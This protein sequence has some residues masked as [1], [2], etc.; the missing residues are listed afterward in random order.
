VTSWRVIE[1][2]CREVLAALPDESVQCC[3]TSPPYFGLRDYGVDGQLGLEP[4]P[5]E[6]VDALAA[7]FAEVRRVLRDDGTLWLNLGDG[8]NTRH[9]GSDNGWDKSRLSNPGRVQKAQ[10]AALRRRRPYTGS[11]PKDLLGLPWMVAFTLRAEGWWLR[12][13][14]IWHKLTAMP[15]PVKDRPTRAHEQVFL[16]TKAPRYYYDADAIA[17]DAVSNKPSGNSY[18]RPEQLSRDGRGQPHPWS[19]VGGRRNRRSVWT[20]GPQPFPAAHFATFPPKLVEP[21]I[22]AG[23]REGDLVLDPFAGAGTTGVVAT[24]LH[25]SFVGIELNHDYCELARQRIRDDAPLLN[26]ASEVAA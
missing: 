13:E 22:L 6:Y 16:L 23:S 10:S 4:T 8:Y 5:D 17:E 3:V 11:K 20:L 12:Q 2:D 26:T 7:I 9:R 21:C 24:R 15:D 18:A 19:D 1:G 14:I 25:R